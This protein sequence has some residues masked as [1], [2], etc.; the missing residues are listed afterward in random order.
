MTYEYK[1]KVRHYCVTFRCSY[2][3]WPATHRHISFCKRAVDVD[4]DFIGRSVI[5]TTALDIAEDRKI[6]SEF[7]RTL[8]YRLC[9]QYV[10][11]IIT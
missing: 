11:T 9:N 10:V 7:N 1:L 3:K 8:V 2:S 6:V 4:F 5:S